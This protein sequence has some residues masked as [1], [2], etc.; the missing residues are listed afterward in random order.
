LPHAALVACA[1]LS[2]RPLALRAVTAAACSP[3]RYSD[4]R[5]SKFAYRDAPVAINDRR[6]ALTLTVIKRRRGALT[7]T[8]IKRRRRALTLTVI[9]NRQK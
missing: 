9:N 7:L 4:K 5:P 3:C 2:Q 8:V 6:N 1:V